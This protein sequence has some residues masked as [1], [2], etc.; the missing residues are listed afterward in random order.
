[1]NGTQPKWN[2]KC[3]NIKCWY[4]YGGLVF[5]NMLTIAKSMCV[6]ERVEQMAT[7]AAAAAETQRKTSRNGINKNNRV[8]QPLIIDAKCIEIE[9]RSALQI[10]SKT[11]HIFTW[12]IKITNCAKYDTLSIQFVLHIWKWDVHR[13]C[14][15]FS[16]LRFFFLYFH[17]LLAVTG[18][19]R[20]RICYFQWISH[21]H[22][23]FTW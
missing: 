23:V 3:C 16:S 22:V 6:R 9:W 10:R 18:Y 1:M 17:F 5:A 12:Q 8:I 7:K 21:F 14:V 4:L 2:R 11:V 15:Q 20:Q 13:F 19:F